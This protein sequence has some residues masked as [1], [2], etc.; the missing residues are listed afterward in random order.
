MKKITAYLNSETLLALKVANKPVNP[1]VTMWV[2]KTACNHTERHSKAEGEMRRL[3]LTLAH[4]FVKRRSSTRTLK[5]FETPQGGGA[6][7][8]GHDPTK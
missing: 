3:T 4:W 8:S 5:H 2:P 1:D 7:P 6:R